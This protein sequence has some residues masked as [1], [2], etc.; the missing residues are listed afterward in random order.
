MSLAESNKTAY[1]GF[2]SITRGIDS[3]KAPSL[4]GLDQHAFL[5]NSTTRNGYTQNR[6]GWAK[7]ALEGDDFQLGRWQGAGTYMSDTGHPYL[8]A[9]IG[10]QIIRFD[11]ILKQVMNLS[12][13]GAG[14]TNPSNL[15][16]AWFVQAEIY[17]L[18][19]D[20]SSVPL[21]FDGAVL[22]R[23]HTVANGGKEF[24]TGNAMEYNNGR[25]WV[26]LPDRRT[27]TGG[28]LAYSITGTAYDVL[29][30][31]QNQF[32]TS[33]VFALPSTAGFITAMRTVAVQDSVLGMGPLIVFGEYGSATVNAPFDATAWQNTDSPVFSVG[34]LSQGP[35]SQESCIGI[36][37]DL[38]YR[39]R[40]GDRSYMVARR[41]HNTWV[42]TP[43]SHEMDR[44]LER[45][46]PYLLGHCSAVDFDNRRL[47][48]VSPF[49]ATYDGVEYGIAWRGLSVLDFKP[50]SSMFDRTQP[51]WDGI[52]TGLDILQVLTVNCYGKDCCYIFVLNECQDIELWELSRDNQFDNL[53]DP[54]QWTIETRALGFADKSELL[55]QLE[56]TETWLEQLAGSLA[57]RI[58]YRPDV[59]RGWLD[60]DE[61][62]YC[63]ALGMCEPLGCTAPQGPLPQY[64][65]RKLSSGPDEECEGCV[66][67]KFA[68]GFEYQFRLTLTG[69]GSV[70]RFRAVASE[71]PED[72]VGGCLGEETEDPCC[73]ETACEPNPWE[74]VTV[75]A[76]TGPQPDDGPAFPPERPGGCQAP[77][78]IEFFMASPEEISAGESA[79]LSW[80]EITNASSCSID[81]GIGAIP[82]S[83]DSVVVSPVVTTTYT[84]TAICG[85]SEV[86][87]FA[88]VYVDETPPEV[89]PIVYVP[90]DGLPP[91]DCAEPLDWVW[92]DDGIPV[93]WPSS[94]GHDQD[95]NSLF[96]PELIAWWAGEVQ[97]AFLA[98]GETYSQYKLYW[99]WY[100][101]VDSWNAYMLWQFESHIHYASSGWSV[102][103]AFCP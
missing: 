42:N 84:M 36:N 15:P 17:L 97:A 23:A 85:T 64:R 68:T 39:A 40:D 59:Y 34:L 3:G 19:Q 99:V 72:T 29:T 95:P 57:Y 56:R 48:T 100:E 91:M 31:T 73:E 38:W 13:T 20:N 46:D 44:V 4:I 32:L 45:D 102:A 8:V 87:R 93:R 47:E 101:G 98:S 69:P 86:T 51:C 65:P 96:D 30:Q 12:A 1:D 10:G 37:G 76:C 11:P 5:I 62:S 67:K 61:G 26:A 22:R 7:L 92:L 79:T 63:A 82:A 35:T 27:F 33:G 16:K 28:D 21:I 60:L 55:K 14:L 53:L 78:N 83:P 24:P 18:I 2:G 49:R 54:I 58:Q 75:N 80:G 25:L 74:Y 43:I 77:P 52:W 103:V 89:P 94:S 50:I 66:G 6:P 90:G 71:V 88:T 81:Q 70:R 41:D 9:S